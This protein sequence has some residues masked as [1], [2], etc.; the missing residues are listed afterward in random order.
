MVQTFD[1]GVLPSG[2]SVKPGQQGGAG[3]A[4]SGRCATE[5]KNQEQVGN[6]KAAEGKVLEVASD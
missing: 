4:V 3:E 6:E 1:P 5:R 2:A